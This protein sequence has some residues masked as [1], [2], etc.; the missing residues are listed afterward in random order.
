MAAKGAY[1][2][3]RGL[4]AEI[5]WSINQAHVKGA[6]AG[7]ADPLLEAVRTAFH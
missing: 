4:G 6:P 7:H 1:A 5:V 2:E 3:R